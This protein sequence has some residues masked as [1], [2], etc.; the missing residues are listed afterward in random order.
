MSEPHC[1][2]PIVFSELVE[3]WLDETDA[4]AEARIDEHLLGCAHCS[5]RL[6]EIAGLAAGTRESFLQGAVGMFLTTAFVA[7]LAG[8]GLRIREYRVPQN[9]SVNCSVAPA[10]DVVI[11]RLQA[12]L[13]GVARVDAVTYHAGA[14][15]EILR[16]VP[17]DAHS[18][19]V[20]FATA[21]RRVRALP[22]CTHR[23]RLIAVDDA[24]RQ[25]LGDYTF[26]HT[27]Q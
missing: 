11:S 6:G 7:R 22:T 5:A 8:R 16:D 12:P 9:G 3:Y 20:I 15:P 14:E 17:F 4:A 23:V 26:N 2:S 25:V 19:E 24:A 10:D 13:A 18:G 27:A 21:M 1:R